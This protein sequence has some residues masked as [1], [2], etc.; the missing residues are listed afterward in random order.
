MLSNALRRK[1]Y[2]LTAINYAKAFDSLK[3]SKMIEVMK[4]YKIHPDMITSVV[5][6]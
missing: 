5:A 2:F 1:N 6:I 4:K 3:R